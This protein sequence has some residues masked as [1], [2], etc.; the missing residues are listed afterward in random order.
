MADLETLIAEAVRGGRL[1]ALT[2]WPSAD[3]WQ[4]NARFRRGSGEGWQ[5]VKSADPASGL[6]QALRQESCETPE[7]AAGAFG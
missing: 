7:P 3:G 4:C 5:C 2:L 1:T 6:K